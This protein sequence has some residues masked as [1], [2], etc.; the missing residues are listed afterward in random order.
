LTGNFSI[1]SI[2]KL[3]IYQIRGYENT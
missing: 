3:L 2:T 1:Y